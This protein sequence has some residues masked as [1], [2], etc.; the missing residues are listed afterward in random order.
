MHQLSRTKYKLRTYNLL[1]IDEH[2]F[3]KNWQLTILKLLICIPNKKLHFMHKLSWF[4]VTIFIS[5]NFSLSAHAQSFSDLDK[6]PMDAVMARND[7]NSP[8][9]RII[10]SRPYKREREIFGGLVPYGK[11]WRTGAN[12]TTE[13]RFYEHCLVEGKPIKK[14]TYA[15]FS[16]PDEDEWTIIINKNH[17]DWGAYNYQ[18]DANVLTFKLKAQETATTVE[19]FSISTR[20]A[21][22]GAYLF[23][24]WDDT[25]LRFTVE[26]KPSLF[27]EDEIEKETDETT[28]VGKKPKKRKRFLGIF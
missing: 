24:G 13:I 28:E 22:N 2:L 20:P 26:P 23:M 3:K 11:V 1:T 25:F 27:P 16:I 9:L 12:E 19:Q 17:Q 8:L 6:S 4:I 7:D 14:G 10:Y 21:E 18:E 5:L 15:L